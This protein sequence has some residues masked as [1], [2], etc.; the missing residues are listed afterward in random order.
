MLIPLTRRNHAEIAYRANTRKRLT[1]ESHAG[2]SAQ[3]IDTTYLARRVLQHRKLRILL[4]HAR[5][6]VYD[7]DEVPAAVCDGDPDMRT[8][9]IDSIVDELTHHRK[10]PLDYLAGGDLHR[11]FLGKD[12]DSTHLTTP[13]NLMFLHGTK[14]LY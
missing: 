1:P 8:P 2:N 9:G 3:V 4:R 12:Y 5:A 10:R 11:Y 14:H 13:E 7:L 6:I